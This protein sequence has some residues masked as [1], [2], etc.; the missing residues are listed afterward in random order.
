MTQAHILV[1]DDEKNY[2]V[3]LAK[4]LRRAGYT[5][6]TADNAFAALD[7]LQR[8]PISLV[9]SDLKMP[10]MDGLTL[11]QKVREDLGD[12]PFIIMTA[13]A[14]VQTA[15]DSIKNG[16]YDYLLKPFDN[17][18]VLV[19]INQLSPCTAAS[20]RTRRCG[21]RW[22]RT[23]DGKSSDRVRPTGN[24]PR[25]LPWWPRPLLPF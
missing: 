4:L 14:T 7:I 8:G 1:V 5:V 17:D 19:T 22:K 20:S 24:W 21:S 10:R 9:L 18:Q 6:S 23:T 2:C 3:V 16:V 13:F 25:K 11:F 15:L 12:M